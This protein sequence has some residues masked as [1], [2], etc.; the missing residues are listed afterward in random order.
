ME[1]CEMTNLEYLRRLAGESP[2]ELKEWFMSS[3][4]L[5]EHCANYQG[6]YWKDDK[7]TT[8]VYCKRRKPL[9]SKV[10]ARDDKTNSECCR[11]YRKR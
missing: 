6:D 7:P 3:Y 5:C 10:V 8:L 1:S 4:Y 9:V 11:H 2:E